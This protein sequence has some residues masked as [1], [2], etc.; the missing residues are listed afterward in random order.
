MLAVLPRIHYN[1]QENG[2]PPADTVL[3]SPW[4]LGRDCMWANWDPIK[5]LKMQETSWDTS[6]A[7][8]YSSV[9]LLKALRGELHTKSR[10][11]VCV[12]RGGTQQRHEEM[13]EERNDGSTVRGWQQLEH[14]G[15][16]KGNVSSIPREYSSAGTLSLPL[17]TGFWLL[18][19]LGEDIIIYHSHHYDYGNLL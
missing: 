5:E 7:P 18:P 14:D 8:K 1:K 2:R 10:K 16:R 3:Y 17:N 9:V 13:C 12:W 4:D 19:E 6:V 11:L 15:P